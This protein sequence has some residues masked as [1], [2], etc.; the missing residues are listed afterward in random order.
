MGTWDPSS[1]PPPLSLSLSLSYS[2]TAVVLTNTFFL[3][4]ES[5]QLAGWFINIMA[6][7]PFQKK[8]V[9]CCVIVWIAHHIGGQRRVLNN[10]S[11]WTAALDHNK[12]VHT[13]VTSLA[14][15]QTRSKQQT[16]LRARRSRDLPRIKL[17]KDLWYNSLKAVCL[18]VFLVKMDCSQQHAHLWLIPSN[19]P[20]TYLEVIATR[21]S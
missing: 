1:P 14:E 8:I 7:F 12:Q 3:I 2:F 4:S 19:L 18:S 6:Y 11:E 13:P 9:H 10:P 16:N 21:D 5:E 17:M 15:M 20:S